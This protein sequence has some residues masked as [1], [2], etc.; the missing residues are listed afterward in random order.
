MRIQNNI[1][2]LTAKGKL[3]VNRHSVEKSSERL[4]S[5]YRINRASDDA[6]GL[7]VSEKMRSQLR[8]IKQSIKNT[9]NG[10]ALIQTFEGALGQT[11]SIIRRMKELAVQSANGEYSNSVDRQTIQVE[12]RQLCDEVDHIAGTDFNGV[13]ML[14]KDPGIDNIELEK[15]INS[16]DLAEI[17]MRRSAD[18]EGAIRLFDAA[19]TEALVFSARD[20]GVKCGDL[21]VSGG[22][23]NTDFKYEN[24]RLTILSKTPITI[25]GSSTTNQIYVEKDISAN[26]TLDNVNIQFDDAFTNMCAFKIADNSGGKVTVTL[27]GVNTLK[28]GNGCAGLQKN[29]MGDNIGELI[30]NGTGRLTAYGGEH[31]AGIGCGG[32]HTNCQNITIKSGSIRAYGGGRNTYPAGNCGAGIGGGCNS[33]VK[34]IKI[35]GGEILAV[36]ASLG[37]AGIGGAATDAEKLLTTDI[38]ISGGLVVAVGGCNSQLGSA[39]AGIGSGASGNAD[40]ASNITISGSD[41]IVIAKGGKSNLYGYADDL[42][43]GIGFKQGPGVDNGFSVQSP[44]ISEKF[45]GTILGVNID[46]G[47]MIHIGGN[48]PDIP[49][50]PDPPDKPDNPD[51]PD[52][53]DDPDTPDPSPSKRPAYTEGSA[54]MTYTDGLILQTNS[55]SKDAVKFTFRYSAEGIGEL[56]NDLDCTAEGLGL[57]E[58]SLATQESANYAIDKFD[59]ALCKATMIRAAFGSAMNRLEHKADNLASINENLTDAESGIRDTDMASEMMNYTK[60][61]VVMSAAQAMLAQANTQKQSVLSL[62]S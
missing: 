59:H 15:V 10:A 8:G 22:T 17:A 38:S 13:V 3:S 41:T 36:G 4:S 50:L 32:P 26:V 6:A 19:Q 9:Q 40:A 18:S 11:V 43:A 20:A 7:A 47:T 21:T 24:N 16:Q 37:G 52:T 23:L 35:E 44:L 14:S 30:I 62:L 12:Y 54:K 51:T 28:S 49:D 39:G 25:S 29:G 42:G 61:Q 34:N 45:T 5:G 31:G 53:P 57:D 46:D 60:G 55:R 58:L 1:P 33:N 48:V 27:N 2:A 56:K